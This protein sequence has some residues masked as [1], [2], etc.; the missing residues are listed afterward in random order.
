MLLL[1][2]EL[3]E[4]SAQKV[5]ESKEISKFIVQIFLVFGRL[6][7]V[8]PFLSRPTMHLKTFWPMNTISLPLS[9]IAFFNCFNKKNISV[10]VKQRQVDAFKI[11]SKI[12]SKSCDKSFEGGAAWQALTLQQKQG[13]A[14]QRQ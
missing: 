10:L 1:L 8:E 3:S 14:F 13:G 2:S 12:S 7:K 6:H 5:L 9:R 4:L 11:L